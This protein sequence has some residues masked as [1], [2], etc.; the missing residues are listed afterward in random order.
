[1]LFKPID[2][3]KL[4]KEN[5]TESE[6]QKIND[7]IIQSDKYDLKD[8]EDIDKR[9]NIVLICPSKKEENNK[10]NKI[11]NNIVFFN[12]CNINL[13]TLIN[14]INPNIGAIKLLFKFKLILPSEFNFELKKEYP[15]ISRIFTKYNQVSTEFGYIIYSDFEI[16]MY[17]DFLLLRQYKLPFEIDKNTKL[18]KLHIFSNLPIPKFIENTYIFHNSSLY[19]QEDIY[20]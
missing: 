13:S 18:M 15:F 6:V 20:L 16:I 9:T 3:D 11:N 14:S 8:F 5:I 10:I 19:N 4:L 17:I 2:T 1:M 12:N 7:L